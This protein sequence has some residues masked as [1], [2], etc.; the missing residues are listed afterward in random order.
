VLAPEGT[1]VYDFPEQ[2]DP[3]LTVT[4]GSALTIKDTVAALMQPLALVP[5]TV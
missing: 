2:I 4:T 3:L 5:V 1:I